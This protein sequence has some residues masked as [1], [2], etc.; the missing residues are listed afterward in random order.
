MF[1]HSWQRFVVCGRRRFGRG[2]LWLSQTARAQRAAAEQSSSL[3]QPPPGQ[4]PAPGFQPPLPGQPPMP[5][6]PFQPGQPPMPGGPFPPMMPMPGPSVAI[7]ATSD[8]VYV[9]RG[10]TLFQFDARD[11]KLLKRVE[12]EERRPHPGAL[13]P[14]GAGQPPQPPRDR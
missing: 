2:M 5:G 7:H 9:V 6:Q 1:K 10:N 4:P 14:P 12:L 8:Y 3:E 13:R 11:L